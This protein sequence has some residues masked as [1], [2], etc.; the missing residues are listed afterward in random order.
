MSDRLAGRVA[1]VT[2]ASSGIGAAIAREFAKAGMAVAV[3]ARRADRLGETA[4]A[5]AAAGGTAFACPTDV[6]DEAAVAALF[7]ATLDRFGR[8]DVLVNAAGIAD[9]TPTPDLSLARFREVVDA[10]LVSAFLCSRAAFRVM[11]AAGGGRLLHVGSLSARVPRPHTAAYSASKFALQGLH[12]SLAIDGRAHGIT[13]SILHPGSVATE[14]APD[15]A[16]REGAI[17]SVGDVARMALAMIDLPPDIAFVEGL[18][19]PVGQPFLG[20][21]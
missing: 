3:A 19:L 7:A 1:L 15:M 5:I 14:L 21:G 9:H 13:S 18:M 6:T 20:R 11:A 16:T 12:H 10:N 4:D 17:G 2:G 8:I